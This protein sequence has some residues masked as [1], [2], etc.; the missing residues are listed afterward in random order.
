MAVIDRDRW[1][2]LAPLLDQVFELA[3]TERAQWLDELRARSP[4][5]AAELTALLAKE[6]VAGRRRFLDLGIDAAQSTLAGPDLGA[7]LQQAL[8]DTYTIERELGGGGMSRV[9]LAQEQ[10]L[11]RTVVIKV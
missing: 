4:G 9:F 2:E 10:A 11:G 1:R 6:S 5:L 3:D 7:Y 8:G